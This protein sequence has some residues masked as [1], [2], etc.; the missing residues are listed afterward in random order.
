MIGVPGKARLR[1]P[2]L[3]LAVLLLA[4]SGCGG[5]SPSDPRASHETDGV[6]TP[7]HA[8]DEPDHPANTQPELIDEPDAG[9]VEIRLLAVLTNSTRALYGNPELRV[10]H[11]VNVANDVMAQ[12]G[13]DLEF[14]LAVIKSVDYPDAYD[15]ATALHH[16]T[17]ADA[18]ELQSVPDWR[19]AYRADLV[20][21][22]RPYVNDGYC[23]YAWLGGYGSD[24]DFSHPLEAD[25]GYSVVALDCS[26]YTLVHE[27]GHNLGL[28]HSRREDPEGGSFHFGA[29]HGVDNDFVT[30]MAT[31]GAFN[32]V[33][34][35]L[36]SSPALICNDQ[37]CGIDAE[38]LT[39]GADA[40]KAIRQVKSQVADYR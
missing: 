37:P 17:F 5:G 20:V 1:H 27:L 18:P 11:L 36:F 28:A 4:L 10:E 9:I 13:L 31:P 35:P 2:G 33:R 14:D 24:G 6:T 15:T 32:A 22:L 39:E 29:G 21:L 30:V 12:S 8:A 3:W 25:Y 40:V 16:L 38:H 26:D 19:E 34:L 7:E 23:G